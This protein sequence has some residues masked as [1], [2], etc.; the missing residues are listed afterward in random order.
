MD[1]FTVRGR[2]NI[3]LLILLIA[4]VEFGG[5]LSGFLS[6]SGSSMYLE[7]VKPSFSPPGWVFPIVW[8]ILYFLMAVALYRILVWRSWGKPVGKAIVF[9]V[10]QLL[11]NYLWSIIFF[12]FQLYGVAFLELLLLLFFIII[13]TIEFAKHDGKAAGLM[14][15]YILWV[16][17]AGLLNYTIWMLNK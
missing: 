9:F 14:L 4:L 1:L 3:P 10:I 11:L 6:G 17:F 15:P 16:S 12:R 8:T 5:F 7:L 2:K 13:T